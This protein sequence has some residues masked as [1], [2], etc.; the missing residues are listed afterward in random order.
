MSCGRNNIPISDI[1]HMWEASLTIV[2]NLLLRTSPHTISVMSHSYSGHTDWC[3]F[4][5]GLS[6]CMHGIV[7]ADVKTISSFSMHHWNEVIVLLNKLTA[8]RPV[9]I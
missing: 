8:P 6:D 3:E 1:F 7:R 2:H 9:G 5:W 4:V